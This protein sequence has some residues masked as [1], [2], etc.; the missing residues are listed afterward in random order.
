MIDFFKSCLA[1]IVT[2]LVLGL[3]IF[4]ITISSVLSIFIG[5]VLVGY[6]I[7]IIIRETLIE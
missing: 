4:L 7:Y 3:T 1:V 5:I 2:I 6:V